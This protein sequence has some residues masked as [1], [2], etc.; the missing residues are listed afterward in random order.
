MPKTIAFESARNIPSSTFLLTTKRKPWTIERTLGRSASGAG[1]SFGSIQIDHREAA[2]VPASIQNAPLIPAAAIR[3]PP[4][5]GPPT[6]V[7][8][9]YTLSIAFAAASSSGST[10]RG[11][12]V[13]MPAT[14]NEKMHIES[15]AST[16]SAHTRGWSSEAF[17]ASPTL[18]SARSA[19][20][21]SSS[22]RRSIASA[23]APP[24]M[25]SVSSGTS[26]VIES[27]PTWSVE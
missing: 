27:N 26:S 3:R 10:R 24:T 17:S 19:S 5:A 14:P 4:T 1:A 6:E 16:Y 13:V 20:V 21:H 8:L 15:V 23:I 18:T 25:V 9:E 22:R 2:N 7:V 11:I 12:T